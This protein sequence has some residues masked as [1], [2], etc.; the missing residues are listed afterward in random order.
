M[1]YGQKCCSSYVKFRFSLTTNIKELED[2]LKRI[3]P[4]TISAGILISEPCFV[5]QLMIYTSNELAR[6]WLAASI[7]DTNNKDKIYTMHT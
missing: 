5:A 6:G 4:T 2:S 1:L 3:D 7:S